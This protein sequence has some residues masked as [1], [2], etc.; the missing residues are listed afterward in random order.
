VGEEI[1]LQ[2]ANMAAR[3][4]SSQSMKSVTGASLC[5]VGLVFLFANLDSVAASAATFAG[6]PAAQTVQILPALGLA[7]LHAIQAFAFD[8][9]RFLSG[10]LQILVSFWPLVLV[11]IGAAL[12]R[13]ALPG[14][15]TGY[16][17]ALS[18][19]AKG[20]HQ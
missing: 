3:Q 7:A 19:S 13:G 4:T 1:A 9:S 6:V 16:E 8:H 18:S 11:I 20:E 2:E 15:L 10:L 17:A 5:I 12:L 14:R